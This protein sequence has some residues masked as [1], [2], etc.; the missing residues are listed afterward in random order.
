MTPRE[1]VKRAIEFRGPDRVPVALPEEFGSDFLSVGASPPRDWQPSVETSER[2]EDEW[3]SI[4]ERLP[5]DKTMGQVKS[6]P[7]SDYAKLDGYR[8]PDYSD[9]RRY[10]K[11]REAIEANPEQKFVLASVPFSLIHRLEYLR[12]HQEAWTDAYL[13]ADELGRLLDSLADV[14]ADSVR[15]FAEIGAD[16]IISC[17]DWGL[18]DRAMVSP[19][20][21]REH[22]EPRYTRVYGLARELGMNT[23]L[24]SCGHIAEL[25]EGFIEAHLQ[26]IQMD[27]QENMGVEELARRFGG[28]LCFWCPVDIQHTMVEGGPEEVAAYARRLIDEFGRFD[29]GF[30]AKWYGSPDAV[31]HSWENIEAM[32]RAFMEHGAEVYAAKPGCER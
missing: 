27:Q 5:G 13:H 10:E 18:Q 15:R 8:F 3:G 25:L 20:M 32:S 26:V 30:V 6:H 4:W 28:R 21:F 19:E 23:F 1:R 9:S 11:A 7:L 17:D 29:G 22:F 12:G 2:W 14:A 16:G 24:H 31:Q